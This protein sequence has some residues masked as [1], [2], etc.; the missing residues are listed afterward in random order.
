VVDA[1]VRMYVCATIM[2]LLLAVDGIR[3]SRQIQFFFN[4]AKFKDIS[5]SDIHELYPVLF[6][7]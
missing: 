7:Q 5:Y 1:P 2:K 3:Y 6:F 4:L